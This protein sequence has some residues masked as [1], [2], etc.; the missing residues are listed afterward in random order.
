H[1]TTLMEWV[2]PLYDIAMCQNGDVSPSNEE[3]IHSIKVLIKIVEQDLW[4]TKR[5]TRPML[6]F[7]SFES[8][9]ATL[10]GIEVAHIIHKGQ[11]TP[12]LCQFVQIAELAA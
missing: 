11:F 6:G 12:G 5:Q 2:P 7:K 3:G 4:F 1:R 8:A 10:S 9:S